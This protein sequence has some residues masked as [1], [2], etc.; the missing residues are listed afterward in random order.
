METLKPTSQMVMNFDGTRIYSENVD[1]D[2]KNLEKIEEIVNC[3]KTFTPA[4]DLSLRLVKN[5]GVYEGLLWGKV[6]GE[7]LGIYRR[8]PTLGLMMESVL[9]RLRHECLRMFRK[10]NPPRDPVTVAA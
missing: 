5:D 1:V 4:Y 2:L 3:V 10:P 6:R 9:K 7:N 8:A